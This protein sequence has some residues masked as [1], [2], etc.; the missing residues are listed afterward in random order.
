[1]ITSRRASRTQLKE[2]IYYI[3]SLYVDKRIRSFSMENE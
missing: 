3:M 2:I 1:M